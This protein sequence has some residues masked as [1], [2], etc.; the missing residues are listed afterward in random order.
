MNEMHPSVIKRMHAS[1]CWDTACIATYVLHNSDVLGERERGIDGSW[2][3]SLAYSS[4]GLVGLVRKLLSI[5]D[6]THRGD[7]QVVLSP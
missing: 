7:K 2:S 3:E 6:A 1:C 5:N 4:L